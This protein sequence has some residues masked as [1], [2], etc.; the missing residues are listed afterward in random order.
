MPLR[1][2]GHAKCQLFQERIV[3]S[4][5]DQDPEPLSKM[6]DEDM[7]EWA[8]MSDAKWRSSANGEKEDTSPYE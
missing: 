1:L 5:Y 6:G 8:Y 2:L 3:I 4:D 7:F